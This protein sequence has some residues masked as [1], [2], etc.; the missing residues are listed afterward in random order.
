MSPLG[1]MRCERAT[2]RG[3]LAATLAAILA[4]AGLA[5]T[6]CVPSAR[7]A[8]SRHLSATVSQ[9]PAANDDVAMTFGL[10]PYASSVARGGRD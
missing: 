10:G 2:L 7:S 4:T 5:A 6:G 8:Y 3:V 1:F 9:G